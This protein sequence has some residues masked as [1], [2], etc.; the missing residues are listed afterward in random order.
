MVNKRKI[1]IIED[2]IFLGD[3]LIKK[4]QAEGYDA[5]LA[6]D[7]GVG[8]KKLAEFKPDLLLLDIILPTK[9]GFDV[10]MEKNATPEL[11]DIPVIVVRMISRKRRSGLNSASFLTP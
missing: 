2:D 1:L 3:V 8:V 11:K 9:S 10:L 5:E 4:L 6:R 7:G